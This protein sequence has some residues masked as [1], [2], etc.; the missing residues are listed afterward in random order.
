MCQKIVHRASAHNFVEVEQAQNEV[1]A[2]DEL[3]PV[4]VD[5]LLDAQVPDLA[6]DDEDAALHERSSYSNNVS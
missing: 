6:E 4:L 1:L 5:E 2:A 3:G